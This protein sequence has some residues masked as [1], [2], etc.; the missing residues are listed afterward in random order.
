MLLFI[1]FLIGLYTCNSFENMLVARLIFGCMIWYRNFFW[2]FIWFLDRILWSSLILILFLVF[3]IAR[4]LHIWTVFDSCCIPSDQTINKWSFTDIIRLHML[5]SY[6]FNFFNFILSII[7][8]LVRLNWCN[9]SIFI[10]LVW[11]SILLNNFFSWLDVC[12]RF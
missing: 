8:N 6:H 2:F 5:P 7:I 11:L 10:F 4:H 3:F 12:V 1:I 9:K